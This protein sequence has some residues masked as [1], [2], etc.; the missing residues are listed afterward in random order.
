LNE[1]RDV[2][3]FVRGFPAHLQLTVRV[4]DCSQKLGEMGRLI[5]RPNSIEALAEELEV[6]S[7]QQADCNDPFLSHRSP[8]KL[9]AVRVAKRP[10]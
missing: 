9:P 7:R 6:P 4:V 1:R 5:D 2:H 3:L 10:G 8:S